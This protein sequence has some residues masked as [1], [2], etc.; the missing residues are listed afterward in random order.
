MSVTLKD[1]LS[2]LATDCQK[3]AQ[4]ISD[5]AGAMLSAG[6]SAEDAAAL[7][8]GNAAM[9]QSRLT[10]CSATDS[11]CHCAV[12]WAT[13]TPGVQA[14]AA[15]FPWPQAPQPQAPQPQFGLAPQSFLVTVVPIAQTNLQ[16]A[17]PFWNAFPWAAPRPS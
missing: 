3:F 10:G 14:P 5:P 4:F 2:G 12:L 16:A 15:P 1:F 7:K 17:P 8:S 13:G 11:N 6:L 9:I